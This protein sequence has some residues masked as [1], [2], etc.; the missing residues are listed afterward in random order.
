MKKGYLENNYTVDK[1]HFNRKNQKI[2]LLYLLVFL[3][4]FCLMVLIPSIELFSKIVIIVCIISLVKSDYFP[5]IMLSFII[6]SDAFGVIPGTSLMF[7]WVYFFMLFIR[8]LIIQR[9]YFEKS[10]I[11]P[12]II[13]LLYEIFK[14]FP[15]DFNRTITDVAF[16]ISIVLV[17]SEVIRNKVL[18]RNHLILWA[19]FGLFSGVLPFFQGNEFTFQ[20]SGFERIG[21]LGMSDPNYSSIIYNIGIF[22][23][24]C[25]RLK[26]KF[27]FFRYL[28][29]FV[30][31]ILLIQTLS[32]TG[33]LANL[34]GVLI[35]ILAQKRLT[36]KVKGLVFT[37]IIVV[38]FGFSIQLFPKSEAIE[39]IHTRVTEKLSQF[40]AG[41][42]ASATTDRYMISKLYFEYFNHEKVINQ[43]IGFPEP[44]F[45][46]IYIIGAATH[47]TFLDLLFAVG[48]L[49]SAI[50][51]TYYSLRIVHFY[52]MYQKTNDL[53]YLGV[54]TIKLIIII[55]MF[56]LSL[57]STSIGQFVFFL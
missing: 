15:V 43:L 9:I 7:Y 44:L 11:I 20:A 14:V 23:L 16:L 21:S 6:M 56:G 8:Y 54:M 22:S 2:H 3:I 28:M 52:K 27:E 18:I 41:D 19:V 10:F 33:I 24:F 57:F 4:A 13:Y 38:L 55:Y 5:S 26:K 46:F 47:N 30:L 1:K 12:L 31:Y 40:S 17:N 48:I 53:Q 29:L 25:I 36:K 35:L 45:H 51:L 42:Y 37:T 39:G 50:L 34:I 32:M 49:G